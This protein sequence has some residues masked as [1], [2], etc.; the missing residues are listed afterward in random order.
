MAFSS[1]QTYKEGLLPL[2]AADRAKF[3]AARDN[4][5]LVARAQAIQ[6][7]GGGRAGALVQLVTQEPVGD[8]LLSFFMSASPMVAQN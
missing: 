6:S 7:A 1:P 8:T 3:E 2:T 5:A 4:A